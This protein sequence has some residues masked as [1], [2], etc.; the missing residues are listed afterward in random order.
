MQLPRWEVLKILII[1]VLVAVVAEAL[2]VAV[3]EVKSQ[4][5]VCLMEEEWVEC[6]EVE[7]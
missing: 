3:V 1:K 7:P 5:P 2:W 6:K 4:D